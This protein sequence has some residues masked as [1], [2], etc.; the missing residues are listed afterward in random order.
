MVLQLARAKVE[1]APRWDCDVEIQ[2]GDLDNTNSFSRLTVKVNALADS[3][4]KVHALA[5][6]GL[7][8]KN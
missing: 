3:S 7:M 4:V 6:S 2:Y 5:E 8:L 1:L